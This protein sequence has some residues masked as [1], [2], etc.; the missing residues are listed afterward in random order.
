MSKEAR[1]VNKYNKTLAS[2]Q[3]SLKATDNLST[4]NGLGE[5]A[6]QRELKCRSI[7]ESLLDSFENESQASLDHDDATKRRLYTA[8]KL[9]VAAKHFISSVA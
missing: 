7:T 1:L 8:A 9:V 2:T 3:A 4:D 5:D 6:L